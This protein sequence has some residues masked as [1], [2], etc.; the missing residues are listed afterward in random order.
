METLFEK[1]VQVITD[2]DGKKFKVR[3]ITPEVKSGYEFAKRL[4]DVAASTVALVVL[5]L[6]ILIVSVI[7]VADS[8]GGAFFKQE[9]MGKNGKIFTL[10]KFRTMRLDAEKFGAQWATE[11]DDRCTRVGRILR[12]SRIDELPQLINIIKGDMSIVGPRP[13]RECF[14]DEFDEYIDGFRQ[15][16]YVI[17]GLT[18]YAQINGGYDLKPEEKIVYDLEYIEKRNF[19]FDIK[20]IFQTVAIVFNHNGAR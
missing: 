17:P 3:K 11:N 9:R 5:F 18:G 8:K 19:W 6:P 1:N 10:Y 2:N 16:L 4:F 7:I 20:I 12:A 14:Y 15:R 13:E